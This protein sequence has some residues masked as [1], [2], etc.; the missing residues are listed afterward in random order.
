MIPRMPD[1][2]R[3]KKNALW[4]LHAGW[5]VIGKGDGPYRLQPFRKLLHNQETYE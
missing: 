4:N 5:L 3:G 1:N 2:F